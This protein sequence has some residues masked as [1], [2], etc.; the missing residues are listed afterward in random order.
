MMSQIIDNL[1]LGSQYDA[2]HISPDFDFITAILNVRGPDCHTPPGRD[3]ASE[4]PGVAYKWIPIA[5]N[6][7][8]SH[9]HLQDALTWLQEQTT[10]GKQIL[11][12]CHV[13]VSRSPTILAAFM[14]KSGISRSMEEAKAT[15]S[16]CRPF[17]PPPELWE[18]VPDYLKGT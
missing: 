17:Y 13:G 4:H 16:A 14:V 5:D 9:E 6:E 3:Q 12:H 11:I 15:I 8:V 7:A 10:A 18:S 1:W 2:D